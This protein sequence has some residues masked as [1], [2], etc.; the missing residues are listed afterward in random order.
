MKNLKTKIWVIVL[1]LII[2]NI[3][4]GIIF[5]PEV[6]AGESS[7]IK[8]RLKVVAE[9][10]GWQTDAEETGVAEIVA[11]I[12]RMFLSIVGIIFIILI[13]YSGFKWMTSGGEEEAI[14]KAK[15][16]IVAALIGLL[17]AISAY[18]ITYFIFESLLEGGNGGGIFAS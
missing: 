1:G 11:L 15:K 13:I 12:I 14:R 6:L 4:L 2:L 18:I 16:T 5:V 8:D 10:A 7:S 17:I 3:S 9:E